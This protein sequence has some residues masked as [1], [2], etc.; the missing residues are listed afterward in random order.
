[1]ITCG[2]CVVRVVCGYGMHQ[3]SVMSL[4]CTGGRCCQIFCQ[5]GCAK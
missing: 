2:L 4:F 5:R 1:M 3:I